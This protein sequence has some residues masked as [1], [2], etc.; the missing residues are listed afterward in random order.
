M[1]IHLAYTYKAC[2]T[3]MYEKIG[4]FRR[5]INAQLVW[6]ILSKLRKSIS[7]RAGNLEEAGNL[8]NFYLGCSG[9]PWLLVLR[10]ADSWFGIMAI[11]MLYKDSYKHI[12]STIFTHKY[13][14]LEFR[15][16]FSLILCVLVTHYMHSNRPSCSKPQWKMLTKY[17]ST[18]DWNDAV[19]DDR[20]QFV[21]V[22]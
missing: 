4:L 16:E 17:S 13:F 5:S 10:S 11:L 20:N 14:M 2:S 21:L 18:M 15:D 1:W 19:L 12:H 3:A 6:S 22:R 7:G 9:L 8:N